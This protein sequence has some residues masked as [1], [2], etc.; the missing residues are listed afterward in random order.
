MQDTGG[1]NAPKWCIEY[2]LLSQGVLNLESVIKF[3]SANN[4]QSFPVSYYEKNPSES[5]T[6]M[7]QGAKGDFLA[8]LHRGSGAE[9]YL[10]E[11]FRQT[12]KP[13]LTRKAFN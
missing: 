5:Y 8:A 3:S 1:V 12:C 13:C 10:S 9:M 4:S 2:N 11:T 6:I 7:N